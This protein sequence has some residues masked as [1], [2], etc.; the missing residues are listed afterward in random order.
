LKLAALLR[1]PEFASPAQE[2]VLNVLATE[3]WVA[4]RLTAAVA[5]HGIT[6]AQYNVLRILRG[7]HP[8]PHTCSEVG[9]RLV[10]RTPDVTRLL[11]RLERLG[12]VARR[13]AAHDRRVVEVAITDDGLALLA[14]LDAPVAA[15]LEHLA[16][17]LSG[18]ELRALSDLLEKL[19]ADQA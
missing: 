5:P 13:R 6:L 7:V 11:D 14:G 9:A 15:A 16:R 12:L 18:A 17:H 2:A 19:R 10:D 1:Q 4:G 3:A 8:A